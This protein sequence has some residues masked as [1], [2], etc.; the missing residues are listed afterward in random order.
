MEQSY[1]NLL[2]PWILF[3]AF[4]IRAFVPIAESSALVDFFN[5]TN[6]EHWYPTKWNIANLHSNPCDEP[7]IICDKNN[8]HITGLRVNESNNLTGNI[9]KSISNLTELLI[10]YISKTAQYL[11]LELSLFSM[12]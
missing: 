2:M 10:F 6:G 7:F 4:C 3:S 12:H 5:S 1:W 11:M 9:P 8:T